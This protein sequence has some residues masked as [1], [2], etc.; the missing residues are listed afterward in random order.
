ML[1]TLC[2][3]CHV[4]LPEQDL[5]EGWCDQCGKQIPLS[6]QSAALKEIRKRKKDGLEAVGAPAHGMAMPHAHD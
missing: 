2:P 6:I 5:E 3:T 4:V 1:P